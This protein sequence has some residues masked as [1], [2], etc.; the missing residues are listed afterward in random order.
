MPA[1]CF[2]ILDSQGNLCFLLFLARSADVIICPTYA[3]VTYCQDHASCVQLND[4]S[5]RC[6]CDTG[7][8]ENGSLCLGE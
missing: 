4:S 6:V 2:T 3:L 1:P 7:F 5:Y 8:V